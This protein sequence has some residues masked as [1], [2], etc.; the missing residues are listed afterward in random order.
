MQQDETK[1]QLNASAAKLDSNHEQ[2]LLYFNFLWKCF[3]PLLFW[4]NIRFSSLT[5]WPGKSRNF[6][7]N[8]LTASENLN[9]VVT[10]L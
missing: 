8:Y 6:H 9:K 5:G 7:Q 3:V 2:L 10:Q 4:L 1:S